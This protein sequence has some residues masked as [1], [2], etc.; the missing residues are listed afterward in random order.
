MSTT[1]TIPELQSEIRDRSEV[2]CPECGLAV[3]AGPFSSLF[4]SYY[5]CPACQHHLKARDLPR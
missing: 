4:G 2:I 5:E 1:T 3:L